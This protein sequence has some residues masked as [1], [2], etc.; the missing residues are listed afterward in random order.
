M[1][2]GETFFRQWR[3]AILLSAGATN[4]Q[5]GAK[6]RLEEINVWRQKHHCWLK[7]AYASLRNINLFT[8]RDCAQGCIKTS[9]TKA[10]S[11]HSTVCCANN[12]NPCKDATMPLVCVRVCVCVCMCE[13]IK[14]QQNPPWHSKCLGNHGN[15]CTKKTECIREIEEKQTGNNT[16]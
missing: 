9:V 7:Y 14:I 13:S 2:Q 16:K 10:H 3:W 5:I 4:W 8:D 6:S 1:T 11:C 15:A 12:N